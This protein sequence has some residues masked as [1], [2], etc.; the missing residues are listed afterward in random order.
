M[1][2]S[3]SY[4]HTHKMYICFHKIVL[5]L[6]KYRFGFIKT[7]FRAYCQKHRYFNNMCIGSYQYTLS[8]K[9][10]YNILFLYLKK[11]EKI[12]FQFGDCF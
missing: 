11:F 8:F 12:V 7:Y 4:T 6:E 10:V 1:D 2:C 5:S 3:S 9:S